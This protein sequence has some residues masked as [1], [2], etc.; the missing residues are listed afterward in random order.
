M[1]AQLA[2]LEVQGTFRLEQTTIHHKLV[3]I[4]LLLLREEQVNC[5][6]EHSVINDVQD[7]TAYS[8]I[9]NQVLYS[10]YIVRVFMRWS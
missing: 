8:Y 9:K 2:A 7:D 5:S 6:K 1:P 4:C 3:G 10:R